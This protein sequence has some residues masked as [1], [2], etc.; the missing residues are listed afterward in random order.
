MGALERIKQ[1]KWLKGE[2]ES[3]WDKDHER[4]MIETSI[5]DYNI[6]TLNDNQALIKVIEKYIE[7]FISGDSFSMD[8]FQKL[9]RKLEHFKWIHL[10]TN[11]SLTTMLYNLI[12]NTIILPN[13]LKDDNFEK[14]YTE[15]KRIIESHIKSFEKEIQI[16][17]QNG[18]SLDLWSIASLIQ[19]MTINTR[20]WMPT[21]NQRSFFI[22]PGFWNNIF[23]YDQTIEWFVMKIPVNLNSKRN[24]KRRVLRLEEVK[25]FVNKV[26]IDYHRNTKNMNWFHLSIY[27]EKNEWRAYHPNCPEHVEFVSINL[28]KEW[29]YVGTDNVLDMLHEIFL[30]NNFIIN[31]IWKE[32]WLET[33][34]EIRLFSNGETLDVTRPGRDN[35]DKIISQTKE[36]VSQQVS[37]KLE[38][39]LDYEQYK[40]STDNP[41]TLED[42]WWLTDAKEEIKKIID[43]IKREDFYRSIGAKLPQWML[44]EWPKGTGKT[45]LARVIAW[46]IDA[47][48]YNIKATDIQQSSYINT[49]SVAMKSLFSFIKTKTSESKK[50]VVIIL[51]E[52][53]SLF[54]VRLWMNGS[55]EDSKVVNAFLAEL[56]G[57]ESYTRN[58]I[59]IGTTNLI[60]NIDEAVTRSGRFDSIIK[61]PLPDKKAL[62]EIYAIHLRKI[63]E[64]W[65]SL[66]A[67]VSLTYMAEKTVWLSGADV[68]NII[69]KLL[70]LKWYETRNGDEISNV[71]QENF[72]KVLKEVKNTGAKESNGIWFWANIN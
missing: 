57:M 58:V 49:W 48:V 22:G 63:W 53:D 12:C 17:T 46:E 13:Y 18:Y 44:F 14:N 47:E 41:V 42:V 68:E 40:I 1:I 6:K 59:F 45:L 19:E 72:E 69:N 64:K 62:E 11:I 37:S 21:I 52:M 23:M 36:N 55:N 28:W 50:K 54:R 15:I 65:A 25:D 4:F 32:F 3:F 67:D 7:D 39:A 30:L 26:S 34:K 16:R 61:V 71:S 24:N 56:N 31:S 33:K 9:L 43:F 35:D 27:K 20:I 70:L 38:N 51:D 66:F 29:D 60:K 2:I 5:L 10:Q 8:F